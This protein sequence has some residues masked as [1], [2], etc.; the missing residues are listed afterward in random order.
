MKLDR[1]EFFKVRSLI[2]E[3]E[4]DPNYA[5]SIM[6]N[7]QEGEIYVNNNEH[8]TSAFLKHCCGFA[9][10]LGDPNDE[11]FNQ[12]IHILLQSKQN[13]INICLPNKEWERSILHFSDLSIISRQR[14]YFKHD[15]NK[16]NIKDYPLPIG[17]H[18]IPMDRDSYETLS[19][20][21]IPRYYWKSAEYFL[22]HG[23]GVCLI[24]P[25]GHI[26]SS[27]F[28]SCIE[29]SCMD[30]GI[31]TRVGY[32]GHGF[33]TLTAAQMVQYSL[34]HGYTPI[35]GCHSQN[36]GSYS[37]AQKLKFVKK[38]YWDTLLVH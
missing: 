10:P 12:Q 19:G 18:I 30:I 14:Y 34:D 5:Y 17:Y 16:F 8:P 35:W 22:N 21:V 3:I 23:Y 2:A 37:V 9:Y 36:V 27:S 7:T 32:E 1:N 38:G 15:T 13:P 26:V 25:E 20:T 11:E 24:N 28:S 29:N 31:Q 4:Y 33:A 6:N